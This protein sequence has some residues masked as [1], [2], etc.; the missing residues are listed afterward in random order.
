MFVVQAVSGVRFR[1]LRYRIM[2]WH[3]RGWFAPF[4]WDCRLLWKARRAEEFYCHDEPRW[5]FDECLA[6]AEPVEIVPPPMATRTR[7]G[8]GQT[9]VW[10]PETG[11]RRV[12]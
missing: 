3:G 4:C 7:G 2:R 1:R 12:S 11:A 9:W 6:R 5:Y 10:T 8:S